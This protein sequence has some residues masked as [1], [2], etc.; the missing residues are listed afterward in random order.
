MCLS[1]PP[2]NLK[3][4]KTGLTTGACATAC[5]K[6]AV[7]SIFERKKIKEVK[8]EL[9]GGKT[10][11]FKI[12]DCKYGK[13]SASATTVKDSGDDPDVT[14]GAVI[15]SK[16]SLN[17]T[18]KIR[19]LTGKGVGTVTLS[20]LGIKVGE[21]AI[22]RVPRKMI[23]EAVG[24]LLKKNGRENA[25][26]EITVFVPEGEKLAKKTLNSRLGIEGGISII[27][28][29]GI[30]RPFSS[31]SYVASIIQAVKIASENGCAHLAA[32]SGGRSEKIL[33]KQFPALPDYAFVQY[34]NWIGRLLDATQKSGIQDLTLVT[35]IGKAVK[36]ASGDMDTHSGKSEWNK[37]LMAKTAK[38]AGAD[39]NA[40]ER[41]QKLNIARRLEEI[42]P[43]RAGEPFY[44]ELLKQ[45]QKHCRKRF[46]GAL[47][48]A[49]VS[50]DGQIVWYPEKPD[51]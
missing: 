21:P 35:M 13:N 6:A 32:S 48:L 17:S 47:T 28:T 18:G 30:V 45:C 51:V 1:P 4:M 41:I 40:V 46:N 9:P 39:K 15:G 3:K 43:V 36:L 44:S 24:G 25:G 20:G 5:A 29:T 26:A 31:A 38:K 2:E 33:R 49:L 42:F 10:A 19:F 7:M 23:A 22:N 34:G 27:G 11:D 8:I 14:H 37:E 50:A 16:V 12:N